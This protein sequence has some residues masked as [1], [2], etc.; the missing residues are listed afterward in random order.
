MSGA[1]E[2][3]SSPEIV[4]AQFDPG[5]SSTFVILTKSSLDYYTIVET[6]ESSQDEENLED[7][8]RLTSA[9][10]TPSA[11]TQYPELNDFVWDAYGK[12]YLATGGQVVVLNIYS[13][14]R[15]EIELSSLML[16]SNPL[17]L[18]ITQVHLIVAQSDCVMNWF[19]IEEHENKDTKEAISVVATKVDKE[20]TLENEPFTRMYYNKGMKQIIGYSSN[21]QLRILPEVAENKD[22]DIGEFDEDEEHRE[23]QI[24]T[25][26]LLTMKV[27]GFHTAGVKGVKDLG[28]STQLC[29]ISEDERLFIWE[30]VNGD[31]LSSVNLGIQPLC[32]EVDMKGIFAFIGCADGSLR[33]YDLS[34]R[35]LPR[36]IKVHKL[37]ETAV[38]QISMALDYSLISISGV[39]GRRVFF[40]NTSLDSMFS[41]TGYIQLENRVLS[42][43]WTAVNTK[44]RLLVL[45]SNSVVM[46]IHPPHVGHHCTKDPN[47]LDSLQ[48]K[49]RKVDNNMRHVMSSPSGQVFVTG[50]D[51]YLKVYEYPDEILTPKDMRK[52]AAPPEEEVDGHKLHTTAW[53]CSSDGKFLATG[54]KEGEIKIRLYSNLKE[55]RKVTVHNTQSGGVHAMSFGQDK[56]Y[57]YSGGGDG[58]IFL[59]NL[60]GKQL[61]TASNQPEFN[62]TE[63]EEIEEVTE[64]LI[65]EIP[66]YLDIKKKEYE[67]SLIPEQMKHKENVGVELTKIKQRLNDLLHK[68]EEAPDIEK[69]ERE[70]FVIDVWRKEAMLKSRDED[71]DNIRK[72][73]NFENLKLELL[74]ARIKEKTWDTMDSKLTVC[75]SIQS[76]DITVHNFAVRAPEGEERERLNKL[77]NLRKIE[78]REQIERQERAIREILPEL[79]FSSEEEQYM[80]NRI[81]VS[82]ECTEQIV[83]KTPIFSSPLT[84]GMGSK[85]F[86]GMTGMSGSSGHHDLK[87]GKKMPRA[88]LYQRPEL[89][90]KEDDAVVQEEEEVVKKEE[91]PTEE[92]IWQIKQDKKT[93]EH[94]KKNWTK[95]TYWELLYNPFELATSYTKRF[96]ILLTKQIIQGMKNDFNKEFEKLCEQKITQIELITEK[97]GRIREL[98][99][100]LKEPVTVFRA[101][102]SIEEHPENILEVEDTEI[103]VTKY[104]TKEE[105]TIE[106]EKRKKEEERLRLLE[107]DNVGKRGLSDM[108]GG[109]L[110][111]KTDAE[112]MDEG[113]LRREEWMDKSE[114]EMT[115]DERMKFKTFLE[116][117]KEIND[118]KEKQR[119]AWEQELK[120]LNL[121]VDDICIKFDEKINALLRRKMFTQIRI[122]EQELYMLRLTISLLD[123]ND[124]IQVKGKM[125]VEI[126][127][128]EENIKA[129]ENKRDL[130]NKLGEK[131]EME[132]KEN[133]KKP[134]LLIREAGFV[135]NTDIMKYQNFVKKGRAAIKLD[136]RDREKTPFDKQ[137]RKK[138]DDYPFINKSS[139]YY[140]IDKMIGKYIQKKKEDTEKEKEEQYNPEVDNIFQGRLNEN[141][142][143]RLVEVRLDYLRRGKRMGDTK[144]QLN[145][146][147]RTISHYT[148]RKNNKVADRDDKKSKYLL[149]CNELEKSKT[150]LEVLVRL[151][152]AQVEL[153]PTPVVHDLDDAVIIK[154]EI[155]ENINGEIQKE[156]EEEIKILQTGLQIASDASLQNL[157]KDVLLKKIRHYELCKGDVKAERITKNTDE[158]TP[159]K[160]EKY[161]ND[162]KINLDCQIKTMKENA[163]RNVEKIR[164][165]E[166]LLKKEIMEKVKENQRLDERARDL[167]VRILCI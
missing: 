81:P 64:E 122:Y 155:V 143:L 60:S 57:L 124:N 36:M 152:Q 127:E 77:M 94:Y 23:D 131:Q 97:S 85:G 31:L 54:G 158:M 38:E 44:K 79:K 10:Y 58:S 15:N 59:I 35:L 91:K 142:F 145:T 153:P 157:K 7:M 115:E 125:E 52:P 56:M 9:S 144:R 156:G 149:H 26:S 66:F 99:E 118:K 2:T 109:T 154:K 104:L 22:E 89:R 69:L 162:K 24:K 87:P 101:A 68:N 161:E 119:K 123:G 151:R 65:E 88:W 108:M 6:C 33:I 148:D 82:P 92:T 28:D 45:L 90:N 70:E 146:L 160:V 163:E 41:F 16:T 164:K 61:P 5:K 20:F 132:Q 14:N 39:G 120:K 102:G 19:N 113:L 138:S 63:L 78:L 42:Q 49:Y 105:R 100:E 80:V 133:D 11:H 17:S 50:E 121:D 116:Q 137:E 30:I 135:D 53:S 107:A 73:M 3:L 76:E 112:A 129:L 72:E 126:N 117:E 96:Q 136:S 47:P 111:V 139:P 48:A 83:E 27:G 4:K 55:P 86:G 51:N 34:N 1:E 40:M 13:K 12:I 134:E 140:E 147:A 21:G 43:C 159:E 93:I 62:L 128:L 29:S 141:E 46:G 37:F 167:T 103:S 95:L 74:K 106:E 71:C 32:I 8:Y 110:D 130:L 166:Q 75:T 67:E 114:D 84:T 165:K 150:N 98:L 18:I 25:L